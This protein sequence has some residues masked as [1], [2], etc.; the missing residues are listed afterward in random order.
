MQLAPGDRNQKSLA[1]M[2]VLKYYIKQRCDQY[3]TYYRLNEIAV[4]KIM[5]FLSEKKLFTA[6][7]K[8]ARLLL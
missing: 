1:A 5:V 4:Y 8:M 2:N 7:P 6:K 3:F